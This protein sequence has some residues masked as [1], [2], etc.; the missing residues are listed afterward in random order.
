MR[1]RA[2]RFFGGWPN[3]C[4]IYSALMFHLMFYHVYA[5]FIRCFIYCFI[6]FLLCECA[7][8]VFFWVCLI[9]ARFIALCYVYAMF[10]LLFCHVS[11]MCI[12]CFIYCF[13]MFILC[14]C[15]V[16]LMFHFMFYHVYAMFIAC[17]MCCL[18]IFC[19][20]SARGAFFWGV[21][22]FVH[23]L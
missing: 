18:I 17:F 13:I 15:H 12:P 10:H 22:E 11:V 1:V 9:R 2:A 23:D 20:A 19:Y 5:M 6:M 3:S 7:R 16:Y 8:R 21:A 4:T 14:L